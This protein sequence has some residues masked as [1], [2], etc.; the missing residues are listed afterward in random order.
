VSK[1]PGAVQVLHEFYQI[2][3][4]KRVYASI[5]QLQTDLDIWIAEYNEREASPG[6]LVLRQN[7]NADLS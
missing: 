1:E 5:E 3:F 6:P 2:A 4:R 7:A